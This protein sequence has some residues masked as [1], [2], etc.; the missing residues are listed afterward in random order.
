M[1]LR[2]PFSLLATLL[3]VRL[4]DEWFG[5]FPAGALE[6]IRADLRL[7]YGEAGLV[8]A[9]LPA[10]GLV[11]N[12]FAVAA[13]FVDRRWLAGAGAA[14]YGLCLAAF[15]LSDSLPVLLAAA[16]IWG[17]ASDAF[18]HG[19]EVALVDLARTSGGDL[20]P[21]LGRV[22][23][24]GAVGDLLGPLTLAG[25]AALGVSWRGVFLAGAALMLLYAAW[26]AGQA[27]PTAQPLPEAKTP[28]AAVLGVV[29]DRRLVLLALVDGLF[30]L[31][32][33]PFL[34]FTIAYLERVRNLSPTAATAIIA[35]AVAAG[36]VGFLSVPVFTRRL[37]PGSLLVGF[38]VLVALA[39]P[40]LVVAP[41]VP[42]QV[43]AAF[44]FG[45]AGAAFYA[46]LQAT[47][48]GLR[49]GQAG[50]SQAIV[51]T[52]GLFG[53]G[54]PALV[55]AVSDTFG[56]TAGLGLYAAVPLGIL[57]LLAP[58]TVPRTAPRS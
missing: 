50:T 15:A 3:F 48:L 25:A 8:L 31:L 14:V 30:G 47:Y 33:E 44:T 17:A 29:R 51:S 49:P 34:G 24:Y 10:G 53:I 19:C 41:V 21:A 7:S 18:V 37:K 36:I 45:F 58:G 43:L 23:A 35:V 13:D 54:F 52:I 26:I 56:L 16:F 9:A 28:V 32:D 5:F 46:V 57:L 40:A 39:I 2:A 20:A 38:G 42:L 4:A 11:G 55:G 22:N 27:F 6:P 1:A 12:G